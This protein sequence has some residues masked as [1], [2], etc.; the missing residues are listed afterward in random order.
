M[1]D[2][3]RTAGGTAKTRVVVV[4]QRQ[5]AGSQLHTSLS[6]STELAM[7]GQ[8]R[9]DR[10]TMASL[11]GLRPDVLVI[12]MVGDSID[13]LDLIRRVVA[14]GPRPPGV[15]LVG[16]HPHDGLVR[17]LW[18]GA[19]GLMLGRPGP[20]LLA[21]TVRLVAAGYL[22]VPASMR[23]TALERWA[24]D[25]SPGEGT[26]DAVL[27]KLTP[28]EVDVL[29]LVASGHSN[30][31]ISSTLRLSESTVKSHVQ[32]ILGKLHLRNRVGI[33]ILAHDIGLI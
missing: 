19:R 14:C 29:H 22:V 3:G 21:H 18:R 30:A 32:R 31:E 11:C 33:V 25:L 2:N 26:G 12:E 5:C 4:Y 13:T 28:R 8:L 23:P 27:G 20:E 24:T 7:I 1:P 9:C 10:S 15:L 16:D 6:S 17:G